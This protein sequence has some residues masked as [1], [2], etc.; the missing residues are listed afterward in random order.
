MKL[1]TITILLKEQR[2]EAVDFDLH[3][4]LSTVFCLFKARNIFR[5]LDIWGDNNYLLGELYLSQENLRVIAYIERN[6]NWNATPDL[7]H[8]AV[9]HYTT[10]ISKRTASSHLGNDQAR[11][12]LTTLI[13][14]E[15]MIQQD[16]ALNPEDPL[17]II[18]FFI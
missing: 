18:I 7:K 14:L 17:Y 1:G 9:I 8:Q 4:F 15:L 10:R 12:C 11:L 3:F 16:M 5:L 2:S 13:L 6:R